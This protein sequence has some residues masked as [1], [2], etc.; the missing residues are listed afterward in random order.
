V[1]V[2][3]KKISDAIRRWFDRYAWNFKYEGNLEELVQAQFDHGISGLVFLTYAHR[4]GIS[5]ELNAFV[6]KLIEKFP[7]TVGLGA[8][9]PGDDRPRDITKRALEE[10]GLCGIKLHCHVLK[11]PPDDPFLFPVYELLEEAGGILTIHAGRE[12]AIDAYGTD[13]RLI[14]GA[15]RTHNVLK[16]FPELKMIVPHL[17]FDEPDLFYNMLEQYKNLYLDTTMMMGKFFNMQID[18]EKLIK[19]SERILYGSDYPHIPYEME[20]EVKAIVEM[21]LG[22]DATGKIL[23]ENAARLFPFHFN[24]SI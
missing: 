22:E 8:V 7:N 5:E 19:Y 1:H 11:M 16:R 6:S 18:R 9:H 17:G 3:P 24:E 15:E 10:W 21:D 12:P 4:P 14:C 20:R 2:F 13:V 23:F